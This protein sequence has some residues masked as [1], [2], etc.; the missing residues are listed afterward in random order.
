MLILIILS[1][2]N[3]GTPLL[4]LDIGPVMVNLVKEIRSGLSRMHTVDQWQDRKLKSTVLLNGF[5]I[6][7]TVLSFS[8]QPQNN[9][10][11]TELHPQ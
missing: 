11:K 10:E 8:D 5:S 3:R 2:C 9:L 6:P 1:N 7:S 4:S